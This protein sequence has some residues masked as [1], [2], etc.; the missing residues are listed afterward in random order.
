MAGSVMPREAERRGQRYALQFRVPALNRNGKTGTEL[1]EVRG[2]S[3]GHPDVQ[4][5]FNRQHAGFDD[6]VHMMETHDNRERIQRAHDQRTDAA[7]LA[8]Q[9]CRAFQN[10]GFQLG[11]DRPDNDEGRKSGGQ[12][13]T[14][15][16]DK[17]VDHFR[18][19]LMK[20]FFKGRHQPD[21]QDYRYDMA[22]ITDLGNTEY[23]QIPYL[24][25]IGRRDR[26]RVHQRRMNHHQTDYR[27][28]EDVA[29]KY[30]SR[31]NGNQ[32]RQQRKSGIGD[33]IKETIPAAGLESRNRFT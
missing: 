23:T 10:P 21:S 14:Q 18:H 15:R 32:N 31:G 3:N 6:V 26:P 1:G 16:R 27:T 30:T 22:L 24:R 13:R 19:V 4:P 2:G 25:L 17:E 9:P 20:P 7:R 8:D 11:E 29:F 33:Q 28:E 12:Y 5:A